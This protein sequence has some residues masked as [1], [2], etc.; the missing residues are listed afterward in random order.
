M[1]LSCT[2]ACVREE[3][4]SLARQTAPSRP[5][6]RGRLLHAAALPQGLATAEEVWNYWGRDLSELVEQC[7]EVAGALDCCSAKLGKAMNGTT[8][9]RTFRPPSPQP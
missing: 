9:I 8:Q 3:H 4:A 1:Y 7:V 5:C 2:H 6:C